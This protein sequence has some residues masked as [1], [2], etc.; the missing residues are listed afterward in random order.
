[1]EVQ[2]T[3][4]GTMRLSNC[5]NI[6]THNRPKLTLGGKSKWL[7]HKKRHALCDSVL[8]YERERSEFNHV[9]RNNMGN[10]VWSI[11]NDTYISKYHFTRK[12]SRIY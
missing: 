9:E 1:M 3:Q 10:E 5:A 8:S 11:N 2:L 4:A 12:I 7:I 6:F